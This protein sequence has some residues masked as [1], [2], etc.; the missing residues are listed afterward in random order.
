MST[1]LAVDLGLRTGLALFG[2]D[3]R[4][5]WHRS[6]HFGNRTRLKRGAYHLLRD[7]PDLG[8]IVLEGASL[9]GVWTREAAR[10]DV[11]VQQIAA[12]TWRTRLLL[13]REQRS[14]SQAKQ[15]A[16]RLA[17]A[18][19]SWSELSPPPQ[20]RHDAAEAILVGLWAVL[21]LGWLAEL[22]PQLRTA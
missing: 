6:R 22:P 5:R 15:N 7:C 20:L 2:S 19:I 18:V 12:E 10:L 14:G 13:P 4:L 3:G 11:A 8:W 1:L 17:R 21:E 9:A 16:D